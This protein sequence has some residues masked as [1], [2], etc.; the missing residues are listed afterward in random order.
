MSMSRLPTSAAVPSRATSRRRLVVGV[1]V[2]PVVAALLAACGDTTEETAD[3]A[4]ATTASTSTPVTGAPTT[5]L[6]TTVP[7]TEV[8]ATGGPAT[9]PASTVAGT[10]TGSAIDRPVGADDVVIRIAYEGGFVPPG[11]AF[12]ELPLLL[13]AGDGRSYQQGVTTEEFPG[14]LVRPIEVR[15]ISETGIQRLLALAGDA[16]LLAPPPDYAGADNVADAAD[17][18]VTINAAGATFEHRAYALGLDSDG[19]ESSPARQALADFVSELGDVEDAAGEAE[20]GDE[21]MFEPEAYRMLALPVQEG[22][23]EMM[24]PAPAGVSWPDSAGVLLRDAEECAIVTA[25]A[26]GALLSESKQNTVFTEGD[27]ETVSLYQLA[28]VP[29]L[30]G[31]APC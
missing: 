4:P 26:V 3:T 9:D 29:V 24:E 8:P 11:A 12:A 21:T 18:V 7:A 15:T 5:A 14:A 30:P 23:I 20:V 16:G 25:E 28:V 6:E 2:T 27:G 1:A 31:D 22:D 10:A 17:T 13:V 19:G